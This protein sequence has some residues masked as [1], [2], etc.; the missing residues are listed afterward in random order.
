MRRTFDPVH[1]SMIGDT[2]VP[3]ASPPYDSPTPNAV[4]MGN[5]RSTIAGTDMEAPASGTLLKAC[6]ES[7]SHT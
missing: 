6:E 3:T 1:G 4:E 7:D 2:A 5:T